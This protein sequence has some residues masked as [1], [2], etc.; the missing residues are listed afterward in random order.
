[1]AIGILAGVFLQSSITGAP[2]TTAFDGNWSV[3]ADF[4][5]YKDPTG[6][7]AHALRV[8]FP[9]EVKNGVLTGEGGSF[10]YD[11]WENR[12]RRGRPFTRK[13]YYR[14]VHSVPSEGWYYRTR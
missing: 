3:T 5:E 6:P 10:V 9:A 8:N 2:D 1:M 11:Q 14:D 12:S 13:R 7:V 4:H